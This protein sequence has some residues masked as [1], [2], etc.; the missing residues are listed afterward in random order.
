MYVN[1][2]GPVFVTS[3]WRYLGIISFSSH[4]LDFSPRYWKS[5][6][7]QS[8]PKK[9]TISPRYHYFCK[10]DNILENLSFSMLPQFHSPSMAWCTECKQSDQDDWVLL[11]LM[12]DWSIFT[13]LWRTFSSDAI[14]LTIIN[15][16]QF[17]SLH[18]A[19]YSDK[20]FQITFRQRFHSY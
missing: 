9:F 2:S 10:W 13:Q 17:L 4:W 5:N 8:S 16:A 12:I 18:D 14:A 6:S 7:W 11:A 1:M 15:L 20:N 19:S 3:C